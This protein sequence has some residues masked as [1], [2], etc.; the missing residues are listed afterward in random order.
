MRKIC[1]VT[2]TRSEYGLLYWVLKEIEKH[3][4]L[5]LQLVVTGM[6]LSPEFALTVNNIE[7]DG[8]LITKKVE[9]LLSSDTAVGISKSMGLGMISFGDVLAECRP[10]I[11]LV[12][13]DRFEIFSAVSAAMIA[14]IPVAHCHGGEITEGAVDESIRHAITKMAH[15]HFVSCVEYRKR[16]IQ[17]GEIPEKVFVVGG[18]GIENINRI[19]L[20]DRQA[21]EESVNFKLSEAVAMVTFHPVTL[22]QESAE[23]QFGELLS[24]LREFPDLKLIF[25]KA[26]ADADGRIINQMIDEFVQMNPKRAISFVSLG[27]LRYLSAL[28]HVNMVIGNSSSGLLEAPSFGIPTVNIGDRQRGRI[29]AA[30]V[31]ECGNKKN[32]IVIAIKKAAN[33]SFKLFCKTVKN[34]YDNGNASEKIIEVLHLVALE[35]MIKKF[36]Y[37]LEF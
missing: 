25:T 1:V 10:D 6:H 8:F 35:G 13:G 33:N 9:M 23:Y 19:P 18:L 15:L 4:T 5:Q 22:S 32:E 28:K 29:M 24:S 31:I 17:L 2:G 3:P 30:S 27:Q 12:V 21:F 20:L 7:K 34:P 14:K 26:N 36:F 16:V 11:M 37:D